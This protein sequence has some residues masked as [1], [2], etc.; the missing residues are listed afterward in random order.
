MNAV[1]SIYPAVLSQLRSQRL[2]VPFGFLTIVASISTVAIP[3]ITGAIIDQGIIGADAKFLV[4]GA[5]FQFLTS[6]CWIVA[7]RAR[8]RIIIS[9][10]TLLNCDKMNALYRA[11]LFSPLS[12]IS[13]RSPGAI[14]SRLE[15]EEV[16]R[17][18]VVA[19]LGEAIGTISTIILMFL[20]MLVRAPIVCAI[21]A[22]AVLPYICLHFALRRLR[23]PILR[24]MF[25]RDAALRT[26]EASTV[27]ALEEIKVAAQSS[28]VRRHLDGLRQRRAAQRAKSA[29][30]QIASRS[31][32]QFGSVTVVAT[33]IISVGFAAVGGRLTVGEMTSIVML[34]T[35]VASQFDSLVRFGDSWHSAATAEARSHEFLKSIRG[36][37]LL[38]RRTFLKAIKGDIIFDRVSFSYGGRSGDVLEEV[39][40]T[41]REGLLH[42][43][44]GPSGA[45]KSTLLRLAMKL[46][47]PQ[48]GGVRV[49]DIPLRDVR[50]EDWHARY[51]CVLQGCILIY[52]S[53]ARNIAG[54]EDPDI[55]RLRAAARLACCLETIE[56]LP[57]GFEFIVGAGQSALSVGQRQRILIARAFYS[58]PNYLFMDEPTSALDPQNERAVMSNIRNLTPHTTVIFIAHRIDT[59][60]AAD[61]ITYIDRGG[62][63]EAGVHN[64]L[65]DKSAIYRRFVEG[66]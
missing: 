56:A 29:L 40:C 58:P 36:M 53:I 54:T 4:W 63:V 42:A 32:T 18:F 2:L 28:Y 61:T 21:M 22:A 39:S 59:I 41:F 44:V 38:P 55:V 49:G 33:T 10:A 6:V 37:E 66:D 15:D 52:G 27:A 24:E 64:R 51:S 34:V 31:A 12:I 23:E 11:I 20:L 1:N 25:S 46:Y 65:L 3:Y 19:E 26:A 5:A 7:T 17:Q 50:E 35:Y 8:S 43:I 13:T 60:T 45:G 30:L 57:G 9:A 14:I 47:E 48:R 62:I 16:I